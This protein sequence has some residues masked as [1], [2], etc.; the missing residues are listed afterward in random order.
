MDADLMLRPVD[1]LAALV[2]SGELSARE[3][4]ATSL[5]RI[6]ELD[7]ALNAF[8]DVD[9]EGALAA[10]EAIGPGDE[11]PFAG[12]PIAIKGNR[13]L[14]G[15]RL[16]HGCS[17]M[18]GFVAD[19]DNGVVARLKAAGFVPVGTTNLPEYGIQPVTEPRA[20]GPTRNPWDAE[21]TPG[22]S[23]GGSAAALAAGMVPI[24]H[25]NDGGGS[26]RIPAACCGLVGLKPQR[27]RVSTAPELG[28][29]ALVV[30]GVLTRT[31]RET[32]A[33]LDVL[34]GYVP[35]DATWAPPPA[36]PFAAS[37]AREPGR[38]RIAWTVTPPID[39]EVDPR[40]VAAVQDAAALLADLGHD[41]VQADPPWRAEGLADLFGRV[42]GVQVALGI[43]YS[44]LIAGREPTADDMEPLSWALYALGRSIDSVAAA[45]D[46]ARLQALSR[47]LIAWIEGHDALLC[48][49]LAERP[50]PIGLL[51]GTPGD[52]M[53]AFRRAGEFTPFTPLLNATGL[54]GISLPLAHGDEGLPVAVQLVGTPASE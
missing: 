5:R 36:E 50:L 28:D 41:V 15:M 13:A 34:A 22:G 24:A 44:G 23:S 11:R 32:A 54:P 8:V 3:L 48:P 39:A 29:S 7:P 43:A 46:A 38:M 47:G 37:A 27:G 51:A 14:A 42:F 10:A 6:D 25:G 35:G 45:L 30:D 16:T 33:L 4:V 31:T 21:R 26:I 2:R 53:E 40:H 52:P 18:A 1:E 12:V 19:Y 17:L 20:F 9:H 49:A